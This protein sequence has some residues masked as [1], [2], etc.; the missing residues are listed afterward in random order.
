MDRYDC[1]CLEEQLFAQGVQAGVPAA[2]GLLI[3]TN[4]AEWLGAYLDGADGLRWVH[5]LAKFTELTIAPGIPVTV[6]FAAGGDKFCVILFRETQNAEKLNF[7][8]LRRMTA[9][10]EE[11]PAFPGCRWAICCLTRSGRAWM[12]P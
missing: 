10:R 6:S 5:I 8:F 12:K 7:T 1:R 11:E 2:F 9:L 4:L 3:A